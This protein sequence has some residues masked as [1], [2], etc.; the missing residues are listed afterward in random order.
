MKR[1]MAAVPRPAISATGNL[2]HSG[3]SANSRRGG[4]PGAPKVN[5][6]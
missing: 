5:Q 6:S 3:T 1:S 2:R 4:R